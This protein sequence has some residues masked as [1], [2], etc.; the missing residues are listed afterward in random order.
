MSG[1]FAIK[2]GGGGPL[3]ANAILNFHFDFLHTSLSVIRVIFPLPAQ[4]SCLYVLHNTETL[5]ALFGIGTQALVWVILARSRRMKIGFFLVSDTT[6]S[7][8]ESKKKY[9]CNRNIINLLNVSIMLKE[10]HNLELPPARHISSTY[11]FICGQW[12]QANRKYNQHSIWFESQM[13]C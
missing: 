13:F 5:Q 3:M 1:N 10:L 7:I 2:G 6:L 12:N 4:A 8:H 11:I 9:G